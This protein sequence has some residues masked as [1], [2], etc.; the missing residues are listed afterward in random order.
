MQVGVAELRAVEQIEHGAYE[1]AD[2]D[3]QIHRRD[4]LKGRCAYIAVQT[5]CRINAARGGDDRTQAVG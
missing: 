5:R 2:G 4:H 1:V 3:F